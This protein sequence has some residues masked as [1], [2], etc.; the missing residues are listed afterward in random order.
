MISVFLGGGHLSSQI[1]ARKIGATMRKMGFEW[2]HRN[3]GDYYYVV[4]IGANEVQHYLSD[5][6]QLGTPF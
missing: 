2:K 6:E 5:N 4:E 3:D 1:S